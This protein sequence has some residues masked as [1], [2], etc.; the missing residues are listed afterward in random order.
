MYAG[1][2]K[3][4]MPCAR[5]DDEVGGV[6]INQNNT[7]WVDKI[8]PY[9]LRQAAPINSFNQAQANT[10]M[11]SVLWCPAW[12]SDHP[13]IFVYDSVNAVAAYNNRFK[14]GYGYNIWLGYQPNYPNPDAQLPNAMVA[15]RAAGFFGSTGKYYRRNDIT[16]QSDRLLVADTNLW[17]IGMKITDAA[18]TLTPQYVYLSVAA[19]DSASPAGAT[20][21]DCYRHGKY[22]SANGTRYAAKGGRPSFNV[23]FADGHASTLSSVQEGY[24]A[25][26]MRYP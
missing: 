7:Y 12:L 2:F 5:Q 16:A 13:E 6:P 22:P 25:I 4:S 18:G 10:Y 1:D 26:R 15:M 19:E 11:A 23:L 20:N 14:N 9:L 8:Y 17:L 21:L 24:K 3:N